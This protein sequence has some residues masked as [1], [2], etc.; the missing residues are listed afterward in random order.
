MRVD[1]H[2]FE[3]VF[4]FPNRHVLC[5]D[6][7]LETNMTRTQKQQPHGWSRNPSNLG[8]R[9]RAA[10]IGAIAAMASLFAI[11][12]L[13]DAAPFLASAFILT[14]LLALLGPTSRWRTAPWLVCLN[15]ISSFGLTLLPA[16]V[17]TIFRPALVDNPSYIG[18]A[19]TALAALQTGLIADEWMASLQ[20]LKRLSE[21]GRRIQRTFFGLSPL[22]PRVTTMAVKNSRGAL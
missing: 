19:L 2:R 14:S 21:H 6:S 4:I 22:S 15:L 13:G 17:L 3:I 16:F 5:L 20:T 18:Y 7:L 12:V 10:A 1:G 11:P 8:L 9:S